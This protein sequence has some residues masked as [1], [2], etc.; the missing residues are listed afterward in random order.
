MDATSPDQWFGKI[1]EPVTRVQHLVWTNSY[2]NTTVSLVRRYG[3]VVCMKKRELTQ[4]PD[5]TLALQ[6]VLDLL[7]WA[8]YPGQIF[9]VWTQVNISNDNLMMWNTWTTDPGTI[10]EHDLIY[11]RGPFGMSSPESRNPG[12]EYRLELDLISLLVNFA[13]ELEQIMNRY[14]YGLDDWFWAPT[15]TWHTGTGVISLLVNFSCELGQMMTRYDFLL[16]RRVILSNVRT[17]SQLDLILLVNFSCELGQI[18]TRYDCLGLD[19]WFWAN[20][21]QLY[22]FFDFGQL[23]IWIGAKRW[24][25]W[26]KSPKWS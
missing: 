9:P 23:I 26:E 20:R 25:F 13:C 16:A 3:A 5:C 7:K 11:F 14:S 8:S 17:D 2:V 10:C 1:H 18:M 15:R 22:L 12:Y 6:H 19:E 24:I 4:D 21:L